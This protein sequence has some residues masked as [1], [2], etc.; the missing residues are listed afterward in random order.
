[1]SGNPKG[2]LID[3]QD[4]KRCIMP[5]ISQPERF[6]YEIRLLYDDHNL[7]EQD[8]DG[9]MAISL[10]AGSMMVEAAGLQRL[11]KFLANISVW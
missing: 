1:M 3:V 5:S 7:F 8:T 2:W 6:C 9:D 4:A 10:S 11:Q